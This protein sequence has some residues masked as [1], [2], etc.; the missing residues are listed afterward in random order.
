VTFLQIV[1]VAVAI[2]ASLK[3]WEI[4]KSF[5]QILPRSV[6]INGLSRAARAMLGI[7]VV[8]EEV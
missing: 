1:D 5:P 3:G 4:L 7:C 2:L 6:F 8:Y